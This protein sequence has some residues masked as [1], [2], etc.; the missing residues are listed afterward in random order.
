MHTKSKETEP[1]AC[2]PYVDHAYINNG[3]MSLILVA[4]FSGRT[5]R[6]ILGVILSVNG[7]PRKVSDND[8]EILQ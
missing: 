1:Q 5:V 8:P 4:Y 6:Q 7:V 2:I 3:G